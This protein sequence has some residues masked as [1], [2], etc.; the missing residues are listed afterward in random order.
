MEK[1]Q[2]WSS[3]HLQPCKREEA[4]ILGV[5]DDPIETQSTGQAAHSMFQGQ[6]VSMLA[7]INIILG[8]ELCV[9]DLVVIMA[10]H[11]VKPRFLNDTV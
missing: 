6:D 10:D 4:S 3:R 2:I 11:S 7:R 1:D 9:A 8:Q 5:V